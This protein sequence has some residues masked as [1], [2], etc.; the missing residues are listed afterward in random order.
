MA[1]DLPKPAE[2]NEAAAGHTVDV[3]LH[4]ELVVWKHTE[5]TDNTYMLQSDVV[6]TQRPI[7]R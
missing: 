4:R 3:L 1:L 7:S 5:V 6:D 2:M